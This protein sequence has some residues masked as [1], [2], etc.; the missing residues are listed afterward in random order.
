[1]LIEPQKL[2]RFLFQLL[3]KKL[4]E[5]LVQQPVV[6]SRHKHCKFSSPQDI[7]ILTYLFG[8]QPMLQY[9]PNKQSL[10]YF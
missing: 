6:S 10:P 5:V 9:L 8:F 7:H 2:R 4:K 3:R 1:M